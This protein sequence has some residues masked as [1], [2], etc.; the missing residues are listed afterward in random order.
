M[1][2]KKEAI[3]NLGKATAQISFTTLAAIGGATGNPV[4]AGLL[5]LP[6]ATLAALD[7]LWPQLQTRIASSE[8]Q[9]RLPVPDWWN[10]DPSSW[11]DVCAEIEQALPTL[12]QDMEQRL[13]SFQG[14]ITKEVVR[15]A[16]CDALTAHHLT[17]ASRQEERKRIAE[18]VAIPILA[19]L[20]QVLQPLI[21][22][23]QQETLL[24]E[25]H[26]IAQNISTIVALLSQLPD[27]FKDLLQNSGSSALSGL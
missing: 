22:Q 1:A 16:F 18:E 25:T 27:V 7:T 12:A 21:E 19:K 10:S 15:N 20:A 4:V 24:I 3:L 5:A 9:L 2:Q 17:W 11:E 14:V 8:G 6:T 23:L 26:A 13:N